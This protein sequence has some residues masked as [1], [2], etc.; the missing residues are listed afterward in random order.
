MAA[1]KRPRSAPL[2][3]ERLTAKILSSSRSYYISEGDGRVSDEGLLK[4]SGEICLA[5]ERHRDHIG[6][7]IDITLARARSFGPERDG[8]SQPFLVM[9]NLR[10][11]Q[12]SLMAYLPADAF[13]ALPLLIANEPDPVVDVTFQ[14]LSRG[15]GMLLSVF[16]GPA[17]EATALA[18]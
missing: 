12:R 17:D 15:S 14:R 10:K 9:M 16:V 2:E 6:C 13:W 4:I 18:Y 8:Q 7:P 5:R 11:N 3:T 1:K